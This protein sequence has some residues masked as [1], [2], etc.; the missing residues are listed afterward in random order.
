MHSDPVPLDHNSQ[1]A[2]FAFSTIAIVLAIIVTA[3]F[4]LQQRTM[5]PTDEAKPRLA[6][7]NPLPPPVVPAPAPVQRPALVTPAPTV[8]ASVSSRRPAP[9]APAS[10]P[11]SRL[12][13]T[14]AAIKIPR[15]PQTK[16]SALKSR[17]HVV[18]Q[19]VNQHGATKR[20]ARNVQQPDSAASQTGLQAGQPLVL[21]RDRDGY[22]FR[23]RAASIKVAQDGDDEGV[24]T[25]DDGDVASDKNDGDYTFSECSEDSEEYKIW[26]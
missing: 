5:D 20:S 13:P 18:K 15:P 24:T 4:Q 19:A 22:D 23:S 1:S 25:S 21:F 11:T 3:H 9:V 17:L 14:V 6:L 7:G 16:Q 26:K 2:F 8:S 10:M 12:A